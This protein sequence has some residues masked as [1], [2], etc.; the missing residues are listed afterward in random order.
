MKLLPSCR[1]FKKRSIKLNLPVTCLFLMFAFLHQTGATETF[2]TKT[3]INIAAIDWC[4][5]IC[6]KDIKKGYIVDLVKEVFKETQYQIDIQIYP[7]SR[8][9][10]LVGSGRADA[11]LSPA[12]AEAPQLLFP[13]TEV[14]KQRMCFFTSVKS[15]W[16]YSNISSLKNKVIGIAADTS[17]EELNDY[18][19]INPQQFQYQPYHDRFIIQNALKLDKERMDAFLF[20]KNS[21]IYEL[22]KFDIW[23]KYRIAGCVSQAKIYMAFS[24]VKSNKVD[25]KAIIKVFDHQ[26]NK[27]NKTSFISQL[28]AK[29]ALD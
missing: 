6:N 8:A 24:P 23:H 4:P 2:D 13:E 11:L 25:I 12:K 3:T 18:V 1:I 9:I 21:T 5:Q 28:M 14:G 19:K 17:I 15:N 26:M 16:T 7:W 22:K 27:L 10:K 20:T 29:Y